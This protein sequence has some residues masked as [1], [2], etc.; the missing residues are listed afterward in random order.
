MKAFGKI[1]LVL[2]PVLVQAPVL[3]AQADIRKAIDNSNNFQRFCYE[4]NIDS[5]LVNVQ[6]LAGLNT[7][8]LND[9]IHNSFAQSFRSAES[10]RADTAS[11]GQLLRKMYMSSG[12]RPLQQS[13]Y[14]LYQW[15]EVK[16]S[17]NDSAKIRRV[18]QG[19]LVAQSR[20]QEEIGNRI[21]RYALLIYDVLKT[22]PEYTAIADTLFTRT[23][24]RLQHAVDWIYFHSTDDRV[25][26][27][28]RAYFRYLTA[29]ANFIK[30]GEALQRKDST[31]AE[32][33]LAAASQFSPDENDRLAKTAYFYEAAM[34]LN[35]VSVADFH[36]P[37]ADLLMA[38]GDVNAAI[39]VLTELTLADPGNIALLKSYYPKA[40]SANV[41]FTEYWNKTL[42]DKLKPAGDFNLT[43]LDNKVL[44]YAQYKGK[45][46]LI[47]FWGTWCKPC[48]AELPRFQK[49]YETLPQSNQ[50]ELVVLTVACH[51]QEPL[52][53]EFMA[54]QK[55][56]FPVAMADN[57]I[58]K[59]YYVAEYPTKVLITPQ[60]NR[61]KI[62]FGAD[63]AERVKIYMENQ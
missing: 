3:F 6:E 32:T 30:A 37:Y 58:E 59:S 39:K 16:K 53:R 33:Y 43:S 48:V 51:D 57:T 60:G 62:P 20:S 45:W 10:S 35:D 44:D 54:K 24:R 14:P 19:F 11:A 40:A 42:N 41:P 15:V 29:F 4:K 2:L 52:V 38:K 56:T 7:R 5:A 27:Q 8:M 63:W 47:D 55:Y 21:D 9:A 1:V 36:K 13:V 61:M 17:L 22:K 18:V 25:R 46:I 49:F 28:P 50:K 12:N 34:L 23:K 31:N 26:S